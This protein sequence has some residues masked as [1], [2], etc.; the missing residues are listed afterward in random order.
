MN[1]LFQTS[2]IYKNPELLR[3]LWH[4][5][6][7]SQWKN[8]T[9]SKKNIFLRR[10]WLFFRLYPNI[11]TLPFYYER[12]NSFMAPKVYE[13][14]QMFRN[15]KLFKNDVVLDLGCGDGTLSLF[16]AKSVRKVIGVDTLAHCISDARLKAKELEGKVHAEFYCS[17]LE[18]LDLAD[19]SIDKIVSFSVIEH[20]PNYQEVFEKI[21]RL[22]RDGGEL[23]FSVDSF[24]QFDKQQ[25][26]IHRRNFQ[27]QKYFE[28]EELY[29]LLKDL[30]FQ[31]ICIKPIFI[32]SFAKEW[33]FRVM[34]DPAEYFGSYKR[35]YSFFLH[36]KF[37]LHEML[38]KRQDHGIFL[39]AS[40]KK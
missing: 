19:K 5:Y 20:I 32:S 35:F 2:A 4:Q 13:Y 14:L 31:E 33:F 28:K 39:V 10:F 21:F 38:S 3:N 17:K 1:E 36:Y 23:I 18:E 34:S 27:V 26:D 15:V 25:K 30:G 7:F 8:D 22:L 11:H 37:I 6:K 40:C 16:I 12:A 24:S 29:K 9:N